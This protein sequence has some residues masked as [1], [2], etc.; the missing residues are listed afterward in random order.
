VAVLED[1]KDDPTVRELTEFINTLNEDQRM[2]IVALLWVGLGD[3]D[4]ND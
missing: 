4:F 2:V 3:G 1:Y